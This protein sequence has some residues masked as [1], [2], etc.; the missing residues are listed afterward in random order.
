M[1]EVKVMKASES[2]IDEWS[3]KFIAAGGSAGKSAAD[4][5]AIKD[6]FENPT[7]GGNKSQKP[8]KPSKRPKATVDKVKLAAQRRAFQAL[9]VANGLRVP[10]PEYRFDKIRLWKFDWA[11]PSG[12]FALEVDGAVH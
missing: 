11:W 10:I 3:A 5:Q 7:I 1:R 6:W 9:C 2:E 8:P 12:W 4:M